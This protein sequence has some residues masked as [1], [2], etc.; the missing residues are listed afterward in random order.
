MALAVRVVFVLASDQ[1]LLYSHQYNY[2]TNALRIVEHPH[3]VNFILMSDLWRDWMGWTI[4]P[5]YYLFVAA[6]FAIFGPHLV[7]IR[8]LHCVLD[9]GVAVAVTSLG[10]RAAG[11]FGIWAGVAYAVYYPAVEMT[12][13]TMTENLHTIL[14]VGSLAMMAS[15]A[16]RPGCTRAFAGGL[17]LG[18][19]ALARAVSSAF[20]GLAALWR[21]SVHGR[22]HWLAAVLI[23]AGGAT[24]ISPWTA[25]NV[26]L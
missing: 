21:L 8:V 11:G 3:P 7:G 22:S 1:P 18:L 9:A 19:S 4:A 2:F 5:L 24:A 6:V 20:L 10:R 12:N 13:Y 25:R 16:E 23:L 15:E 17:A 26:F 14:L